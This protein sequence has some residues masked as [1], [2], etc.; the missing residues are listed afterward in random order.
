MRTQA[1][2]GTLLSGMVLWAGLSTQAWAAG[3]G[4]MTVRSMLGQPLVADIELVI[5]DRKELEGLTARIASVEAHRGANVPYN[6]SALGLKAVIQQGKDG[7]S[8]IRVHSDKPVTEPA[9]KL[10]IELMSS[11]APALRE[12]NALLEP[13]EVQRK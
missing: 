5:R 2:W 8:Y 6:A 10:L 11:G 12:Y 7:R 9:V 1:W 4:Q 3:M 13:P